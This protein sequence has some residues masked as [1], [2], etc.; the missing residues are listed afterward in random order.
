MPIGD[1]KV[2][3]ML[4]VEQRARPWTGFVASVAIHAA[5]IWGLAVIGPEYGLTK[6]QA[7]RIS[8]FE[9]RIGEKLYIVS[10]LPRGERE[11][12]PAAKP[13]NSGGEKS[14]ASPAPSI[15]EPR[16][17]RAPLRAWVGPTAPQPRTPANTILYQPLI[18]PQVQAAEVP[19]PNVMLWTRGPKLPPKPL[20]APGARAVPVPASP[21]IVAA[22]ETL[23]V[24]A[25]V[26]ANSAAKLPVA[27]I[28]QGPPVELLSPPS[29]LAAAA[30]STLPG[31]TVRVLAASRFPLPPGE[32]IKIPHGNI[33]PGASG[34]AGAASGVGGGNGRG[35][36]ASGSG[37]RG[38]SGGAEG[39][40]GSGAGAGSGTGNGRA[41]V[42]SGG[43]AERTGGGPAGL[44]GTGPAGPGVA[45]ALPIGGGSGRSEIDPTFT[46]LVR[47]PTGKFDAIV[48]QSV[49]LEIFDDSASL[50][51]GRPVY[52]VYLA[53]GTPKDWILQYCVPRDSVAS[54]SPSG[55]IV[56]ISTPAPLTAPWPTF[57]VRPPVAVRPGEKYMVVHGLL[58]DTGKFERVKVVRAGAEDTDARLVLALRSWEFRPAMKDGRPIAVEFL[59]AVPPDRM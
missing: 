19:L 30:S 45:G 26:P 25:G 31:D 55:N 43:A 15:E 22:P 6:P 18:D 23:A 42:G 56:R 54:L 58:N 16:A 51:T 44:G 17:A 52:T 2:P 27:Q 39:R 21:Q 38:G 20:V 4:P 34:G 36:G 13:A 50:L 48:V 40:D 12:R 1:T 29:E 41:T 33:L 35:G 47:P 9:I 5:A 28:T 37:E 8:E 11:T 7:R 24:A 3:L 32:T 53:M 49:P 46:R 10:A 14:P 57:M 59:L